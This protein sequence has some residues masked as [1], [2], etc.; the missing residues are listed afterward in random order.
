MGSFADA[1]CIGAGWANRF[2]R[3]HA[4]AALY[5]VGVSSNFGSQTDSPGDMKHAV[6]SS[7]ECW[8]AVPTPQLL[9]SPRGWLTTRRWASSCCVS[10]PSAGLWVS[11]S[12]CPHCV[13]MYL[14]RWPLRRTASRDLELM[15]SNIFWEVR[16]IV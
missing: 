16:R 13:C 10:V 7:P 5:V 1:P 2:R 14:G 8:Q 6:H 3:L 12:M 9:P 15:I 4:R 11:A